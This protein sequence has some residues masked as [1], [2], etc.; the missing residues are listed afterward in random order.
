MT[1]RPDRTDS[2]DLRAGTRIGR[3]GRGF[4]ALPTPVVWNFLDQARAHEV[5][6]APAVSLLGT[7]TQLRGDLTD[8]YGRREAGLHARLLV[9]ESTWRD[10]RR[11]LVTLGW[12]APATGGIPADIVQALDGRAS[13]S[14]EAF[15]ALD[16]AGVAGLTEALRA[17]GR[18]APTLLGLLVVLTTLVGPDGELRISPAE[19]AARLGVSMTTVS[20]WLTELDDVASQHAPPES[21]GD[22]TSLAALLWRLEGRVRPD[23]DVQRDGAEPTV[24]RTCQHLGCTSP[25]DDSDVAENSGADTDVAARPAQHSADVVKSV[26]PPVAGQLHP[27]L[28]QR[29]G[30]RQP[31]NSQPSAVVPALRSRAKSHRDPSASF[32]SWPVTGRTTNA[33]W[34][35]NRLD[36]IGYTR[37]AVDEVLAR[38]AQRRSWP[39]VRLLEECRGNTSQID[40]FRASG[41]VP[42]DLARA[43]LEATARLFGQIDQIVRAAGVDPVVAQLHDPFDAAVPDQDPVLAQIAQ[44]HARLAPTWKQASAHRDAFRPPVRKPRTPASPNAGVDPL[45]QAALDSLQRPDRNLA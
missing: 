32:A 41:V 11:L 26:S 33:A 43:R 16:R 36:A 17:K 30:N 27:P 29:L 24:T 8:R 1:G 35:R 5:G 13:G 9:H 19:L 23:A 38:C 7:M 28:L 39:G 22:V 45:L 4:A 14:G 25:P 37:V 18:L 6:N 10:Q 20:R 3:G 44:L 12:W 21:A 2:D 40:G 31:M 34:T 15:V 42:P